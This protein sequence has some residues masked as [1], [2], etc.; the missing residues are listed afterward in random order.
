MKAVSIF[1]TVLLLL[2]GAL[3]SCHRSTPEI[4]SVEPP[5]PTEE[6]VTPAPTSEPTHPSTINKSINVE[7][8]SYGPNES[9]IDAVVIDNAGK[10]IYAI[11][12]TP[13]QKYPKCVWKMDF[14][15]QSWQYLGMIDDLEIDFKEE[16]RTIIYEELIR[17]FHRITGGRSHNDPFGEVRYDPPHENPEKKDSN[18]PNISIKLIYYDLDNPRPPFEKYKFLLS[19]NGGESWSELNL[20]SLY[21]YDSN[22]YKI[23]PFILWHQYNLVSYEGILYLFCAQG[24]VYQAAINLKSIE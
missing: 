16:L 20:P 6:P 7:W 4:P 11:G 21:D 24:K 8:E 22:Q 14:G 5:A 18:N 19:L 3:V 15:S 17:P 13:K 23:Q 2:I 12:S 9:D 1:L 10:I